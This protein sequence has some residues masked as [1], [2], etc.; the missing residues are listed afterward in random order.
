[1][2]NK[3]NIFFKYFSKELREKGGK[4]MAEN[5]TQVNSYQDKLLEAM[6]IVSS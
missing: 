4:I 2:I 1:M 6:S 5:L 3:L